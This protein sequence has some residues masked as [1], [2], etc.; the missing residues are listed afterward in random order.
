[1]SVAIIESMRVGAR[2]PSRR[3]LLTLS[4]HESARWVGAAHVVASVD[5][6]SPSV[7]WNLT[8]WQIGDGQVMDP[9]EAQ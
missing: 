6:E 4:V 2:L 8:E 3:L 5:W 7:A 9:S 1:M